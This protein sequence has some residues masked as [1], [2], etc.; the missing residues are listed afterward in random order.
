MSWWVIPC[1]VTG[2]YLG[3]C[4]QD[5]IRGM[6][7][8]LREDRLRKLKATEEAEVTRIRGGLGTPLPRVAI[9]PL[10]FKREPLVTAVLESPLVPRPS[11]E[12]PKRTW[13][14]RI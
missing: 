2:G 14:Q 11:F 9:S 8:D 5:Q 12:E 13:R 6:L 7:Q 10:A 3:K 4:L 1:L